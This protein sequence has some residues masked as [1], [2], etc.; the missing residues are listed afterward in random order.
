MS[1]TWIKKIHFSCPFFLL[2]SLFFALFL[3]AVP[4]QGHGSIKLKSEHV[5]TRMNCKECHHDYQKGYIPPPGVKLTTR[6]CSLCHMQGAARITKYSELPRMTKI[7]HLRCVKC[8]EAFLLRGNNDK[9]RA[10]LEM[11]P[12]S[13]KA[14]GMNEGTTRGTKKISQCL[15]CH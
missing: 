9:L 1:D 11:K 14:E 4:E 12:G 6:E 2:M 5:T 10:L 13:D 15:V 3:F 8:H 7:L